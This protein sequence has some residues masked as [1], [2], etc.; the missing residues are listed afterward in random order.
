M[1]KNAWLN[2]KKAFILMRIHTAVA[3]LNF[4][5]LLKKWTDTPMRYDMSIKLKAGVEQRKRR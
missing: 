1:L 5:G 2:I 4:C 3:R